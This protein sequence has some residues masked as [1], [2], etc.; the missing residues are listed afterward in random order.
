LLAKVYMYLMLLDNTS[1]MNM[2]EGGA[3]NMIEHETSRA[4]L[5]HDL[6]DSARLLGNVSPSFLR[7]EMARGR[8][9][10][11]KLGRRLVISHE[12]L[13]RYLASGT[14]RGAAR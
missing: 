12:E 8:L 11:S 1:F 14:Q 2:R 4:P 5:A 3:L 10:G 9:R 6:K 7:L 13:T